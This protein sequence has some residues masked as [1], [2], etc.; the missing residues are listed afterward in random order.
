MTAKHVNETVRLV[1]SRDQA[2]PT[3][4]HVP[5]GHRVLPSG[6]CQ[7]VGSPATPMKDLPKKD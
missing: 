6:V 5:S 4:R 7:Q 2:R 1:R 3:W